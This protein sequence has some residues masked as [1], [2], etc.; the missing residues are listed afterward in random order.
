[1]EKVAARRGAFVEPTLRPRVLTVPTVTLLFILTADTVTWA[2]FDI[3]IDVPNLAIGSAVGVGEGVEKPTVA[4]Y[5][6]AFD[7][8]VQGSF[9]LVAG[10]STGIVVV[11]VWNLGLDDDDS[12]GQKEGKEGF[13]HGGKF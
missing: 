9:Q 2:V 7:N 11:A 3:G 10:F 8:I 6:M 5:M 12:E 13:S 4:D 1:M